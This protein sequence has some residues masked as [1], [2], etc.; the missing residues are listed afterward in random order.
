MAL[1]NHDIT[2]TARMARD[3][4][5]DYLV[6]LKVNSKE[7]GFPV[8][9]LAR[10]FDSKEGGNDL[11][12]KDR[13]GVVGPIIQNADGDTYNHDITFT[14]KMMMDFKTDNR[15]P[16][17][18]KSQFKKSGAFLFVGLP[19]I[20]IKKKVEMVSRGRIVSPEKPKCGII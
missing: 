5:T 18:F 12:R 4:E 15:L 7:W 13:Q 16:C 6:H 17:P 20:L 1:P 2:F 10:Y 3:F 8:C 19:D 9:K 11:R 14:A